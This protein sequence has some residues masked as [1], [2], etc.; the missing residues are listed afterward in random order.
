MKMSLFRRKP[1][2]DVEL[3]LGEKASAENK[4]DAPGLTQPDSSPQIMVPPEQN[5]A[6]KTVDNRPSP[7]DRPNQ[8]ALM[9]SSRT[10]SAGFVPEIPRRTIDL[11]GAPGRKPTLPQRGGSAEGKRLTVGR[12]IS[13]SGEITACETLI[14]EGAVEATLENSQFLE[15]AEGGIFKGTVV[16][17]EAVISGTF[18]GAITARERLT[19]RSTGRITGTVRFSQIEIELGGEI[20][21][22]IN[23]LQP[24][25][26]TE[27]AAAT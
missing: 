14:V 25:G 22:E 21:G 16:I 4:A 11:S 8:G 10:P 13:L 6:D 19:V 17:D 1:P 7:E 18:N 26:S 5:G 24:Q 2:E 20:N 27:A 12:E 23:V 9:A 3:K 15:V